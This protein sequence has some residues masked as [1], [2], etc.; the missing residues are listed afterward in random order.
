MVSTSQRLAEKLRTAT[1]AEALFDHLGVALSVFSNEVA[2]DETTLAFLRAGGL[3]TLIRHLGAPAAPL[4]SPHADVT[5][6]DISV[7]ISEV[8][9]AAL[10]ALFHRS[11]AVT[12]ELGAATGVIPALADAL[13]DAPSVIS[14][15]VA[16]EALC[17][18]AK[19]QPVRCK[20][21]AEAGV[22]GLLLS[23]HRDIWESD[24][25]ASEATE[26]WPPIVGL[27]NMLLGTQPLATHQ[28]GDA[29]RAVDSKE[30]FTALIVLQVCHMRLPPFVVNGDKRT[31]NQEKCIAP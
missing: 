21:M 2:G 17:V 28:L 10:R 25:D 13:R 31:T 1:S 5:P 8:A 12:A 14:R 27:A 22:M 16:A 20:Q 29:I 7:A 11:D 19:A 15:S 9:G 3:P 4:R 18:L 23:L 26:L 24:A 6:A 30:S